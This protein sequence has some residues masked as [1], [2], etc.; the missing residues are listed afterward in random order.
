MGMMAG[1]NRGLLPGAFKMKPLKRAFPLRSPFLYWTIILFILI[2]NFSVADAQSAERDTSLADLWIDMRIGPPLVDLFNETA[3][4]EDI[5]RIDRPEQIH[6]L[7][8]I[9]TGRKLVVFRSIAEMEQY[10]PQMASEF[11]IVGYN[12]ER[13]GPTPAAEQADL[14]ASVRQVRELVDQYGLELA[15]GPDQNYAVANGVELAPYADIFVLQIQRQQTNPPLVADYVSSLAP[16]LRAANPDLQ[17]SVQVRTEGDVR[18][19]IALLD[20]LMGHL[21][22][23]SILTSPD[24]VGIA[25][26]LVARLRP[27]V[28]WPLMILLAVILVVV[29]VGAIFIIRRR[30]LQSS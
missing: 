3:R 18:E 12:V 1:N 16:N 24:T 27:A 5:A 25:E 23:V 2:A 11:D 9:T 7:A 21:D 13:G 29:L 17:I 6:Q 14:L 30:R 8:G 10:L 26:D 20:S 4:P 22:G 19:I 15:V 28:N